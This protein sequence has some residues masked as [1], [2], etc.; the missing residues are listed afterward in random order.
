L[1]DGLP[2]TREVKV[3]MHLSPL[4]FKKALYRTWRR[5]CALGGVLA[6]AG[7][8]S[9]GAAAPASP[10]ARHQKGRSFSRFEDLSPPGDSA[11]AELGLLSRFVVC[12]ADP[13]DPGMSFA[14]GIERP[15]RGLMRGADRAGAE[16]GPE[17]SKKEVSSKGWSPCKPSRRR[18]RQAT[19]PRSLWLGCRS[20]I[21][22]Q[23]ACCP[24]WSS[25]PSVG[26]A[27]PLGVGM[28]FPLAPFGG[29]CPTVKCGS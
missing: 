9:G 4:S 28:L 16:V 18:H 27:V 3:P 7:G 25:R 2:D 11:G 14:P 19:R 6:A 5:W 8:G 20:K 26:C 23:A 10:G 1:A 24:T 22:T 15:T 17:P 13:P 12:I 21:A 29:S